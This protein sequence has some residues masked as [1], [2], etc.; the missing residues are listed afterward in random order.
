MYKKAMGSERKSGGR[1]EPPVRWGRSSGALLTAAAVLLIAGCAG[2]GRQSAA[3]PAPLPPDPRTQAALLQIATAFNHD[4]DRGDYGPVYARWD[5]RSR[6]IISGAEYIRRHRECPS[7]PQPA[8]VTESAGP[9]P[10]GAWLVHYEIGGQQLTDYWFY[11]RHRWVFDLVL[12]NP[13][14]V[15]LYRMSPQRYAA[16]V[17]CAGE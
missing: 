10:R 3:S 6:A 13:D 11:V 9:G 2:G 4:Y 7:P 5:A 16:A 1:P 12:S 8:S 15:R 14:A 17:G